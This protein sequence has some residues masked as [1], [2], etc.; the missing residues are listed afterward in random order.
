[1]FCFW[2]GCLCFLY[3]TLGCCPNT[4]CTNACLRTA[5]LWNVMF[6]AQ[7]QNKKKKEREKFPKNHCLCGFFLLVFFFFFS[8]TFSFYLTVSS[9]FALAFSVFSHLDSDVCLFVCSGVWAVTSADSRHFPHAISSFLHLLPASSELICSVC[10]IWG[11]SFT[12][13][14]S[15]SLSLSLL[16]LSLSS[17]SLSLFSLSLSLSLSFSLSL[18]PS[19]SIYLFLS[20][21]LFLLS[22]LELYQKIFEEFC[23]SV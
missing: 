10:E 7:K 9:S 3:R 22:S 8:W 5:K 13:S 6:W 14:L 1:M 21:F 15:L 17:L 23:L 16:S 4:P 2:S 12:L 18:P 19:L 20:P 11:V